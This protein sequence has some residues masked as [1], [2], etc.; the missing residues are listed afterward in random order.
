M[1]IKG[2][3]YRVEKVNLKHNADSM[4]ILFISGTITLCLLPFCF[5]RIVQGDWP[6]AALNVTIT[7]LSL[8]LFCHAYFTFKTTFAR[9]GLSILSVVAMLSTI[10]L[11]GPEQIFWLYPALTTVFYMLTAHFAAI[12]GVI[13]LLAATVIVYPSVDSFYLL[14]VGST[15]TITFVF[16]YAFSAKMHR[17]AYF[18]RSEAQTDA[19]THLGNR[20]ALDVKL[21]KITNRKAIEQRSSASLLVIDIDHFKEINDTHG[22]KYGDMVLQEFAALILNGIRGKDSAFRFGG[23]EFVIILENT[24]L[25]GA[26][27]LANNLLKDIESARWRGLENKVITASGGV[28]EFN[29][30]ETSSDWL[31]RADTALYAAKNAGRNRCVAAG[32]EDQLGVV[33]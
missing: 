6:I 3:W 25:A 33:A 29:L 2:C 26:L 11:N 16:S 13:L 28:A 21:A 23:E 7:S 20:R 27:T 17:Q 19:L 5:I 10:Y 15:A 30:N 9:W 1:I 8:M 14:T 32:L 4:I 31:L 18:L 22:H 24:D 12:L